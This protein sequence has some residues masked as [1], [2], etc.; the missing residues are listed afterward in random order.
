[1]NQVGGQAPVCAWLVADAHLILLRL[2]MPMLPPLAAPP[3]LDMT[4][5]PVSTCSGCKQ[6][7]PGNDFRLMQSPH[8]LAPSHSHTPHVGLDDRLESWAAAEAVAAAGQADAGRFVLLDPPAAVRRLQDRQAMLAPLAASASLV[9]QQDKQQVGPGCCRDTRLTHD[10][11]PHPAASTP[12]PNG[13]EV[14][15]GLRPP[16]C[17]T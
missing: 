2:D 11:P 12:L 15:V 10:A 7:E 5:S 13:V 1:M 9:L 3:M 4:L 14:T 6:S 16:R 8:S 17:G